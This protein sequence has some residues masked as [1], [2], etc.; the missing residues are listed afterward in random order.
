MLYSTSLALPYQSFP[1]KTKMSSL[2]KLWLWLIRSSIHPLA[3]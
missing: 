1:L 2:Q 3:P